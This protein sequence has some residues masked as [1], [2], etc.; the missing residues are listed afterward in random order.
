[1][2]SSENRSE[3]RRAP[4]VLG[5]LKSVGRDPR[6]L[7]A[8]LLSALLGA[9]AA[10]TPSIGDKCVLSTDCSTRGDRLCDTSQ[11]EGYCTQFN[12]QKNQCPDQAA[13]VLFNAA[14]P[15]CGYDDRSGGYGSRVARSFCVAMCASDKDC[16][17]GYVCANP[18]APPWSGVVLDDDQSKRTCLVPPVGFNV[19][20]GGD[21]SIMSPGAPPPVCSAVA[22]DVAPID[23]SAASVSDGSVT[24]PPVVDASTLD[25]A[26]AAD[27][28]DAG[29][30]G[31]GG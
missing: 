28:R 6:S 14:V 27:A 19:D 30:G 31:D 3:H 16:R 12:C 13:C 15:G 2:S 17:A 7:S 26:D 21:G 1:L 20:A 11:P 10:C 18:H 8:L 25:A 4:S 5:A 23:A 9:L 24:P 29:D 22:P